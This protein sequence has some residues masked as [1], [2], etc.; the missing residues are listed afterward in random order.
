MAAEN[1]TSRLGIPYYY[2]YSLAK[3][4]LGFYKKQLRKI[5]LKTSLFDI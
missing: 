2:K 5:R 4:Q 1:G 3:R